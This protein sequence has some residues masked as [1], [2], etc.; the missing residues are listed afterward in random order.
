MAEVADITRT[1]PPRT[2]IHTTIQWGNIIRGAAIVAA[3]VVVGVVAFN[4]AMPFIAGN[5][6]LTGMI[7][8]ISEGVV[9]A[10]EALW[11]LAQTIGSVIGNLTWGLLP[12]TM[13]TAI[14][15]GNVAGGAATAAQIGAWAVGGAAALGAAIFL[16]APQNLWHALTNMF[17]QERVTIPAQNEVIHQGHSVQDHNRTPREPAQRRELP[18]QTVETVSGEPANDND[19]PRVAASSSQQASW[20]E[21]VPQPQTNRREVTQRAESF[22]EQIKQEQ[23]VTPST[24]PAL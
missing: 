12:G 3:V 13:Q 22:G 23:T 4:V 7:G 11:G 19:R 5:S 2:E 21:R 8:G 15:T 1:T 6:F 17:S 9:L 14:T 20:A 18:P 16:K 10:G 24:L